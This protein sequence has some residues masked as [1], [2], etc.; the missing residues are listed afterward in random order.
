MYSTTRAKRKYDYLLGRLESAGLIQL[1]GKGDFRILDAKHKISLI[2][3]QPDE[4]NGEHVI[5]FAELADIVSEKSDDRSQRFAP[6]LREWM[7]N[8][9]ET[10]PHAFCQSK[11]IQIHQPLQ[12]K[13]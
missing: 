8:N 11:G 12:R 5:T 2:Y 3:V 4:A 7:T 1:S 10:S 13:T 6:S 9:P